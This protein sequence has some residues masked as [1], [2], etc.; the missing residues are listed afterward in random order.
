MLGVTLDATE[1]R[2]IVDMSLAE[3]IGR[4]DLTSAATIPGDARLRAVM[5]ARQPLVLAGL[6]L[7]EAVCRTCDPDCDM[8]I[9]ARDGDSVAEGAPIL[10]IEGNA[11]A[12]LTAERSALNI[13]QHLSGIATLTASYVARI[14]HTRARLLDTRKTI[15][16]LRLAA[17]YA[18][19]M[20]G[21]HNHRMR[22]DD[23][24]LIK[25]NHIARAGSVT[26]AVAAARRQ[27]IS[28]SQFGIAVE[29]DTLDQVRQAVAA[30]ADRLLLDNMTP[31][32][33]REAVAF[34]D[35]R[36]PLEASGGVTLDSIGAIA[37]T[38]VDFISVGRITQSAPAVDIGLDYEDL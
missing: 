38:G 31:G 14:S 3:D 26:A 27:D 4:G 11:R 8:T 15:P 21:G 2:R 18:V 24:V 34:V 32:Q 5:A 6:A 7:A 29:C 17:K 10:R 19:R 9:L 37:E 33:L 1:I 16:G 35:G 12:L 25:D 36:I 13:L 28:A 23:G 20:G 30:G 22:L